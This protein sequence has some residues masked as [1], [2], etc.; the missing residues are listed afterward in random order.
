MTDAL[1]AG[2]AEDP[3]RYRV[4]A[5]AGDPVGA[6]AG[7]EGLVFRA[8]ATGDEDA[9]SFALKMLTTLPLDRYPQLVD[10]TIP[11]LTVDHPHLM[12]HVET[13]LG[14]ALRPQGEDTDDF[15]VPYTVAEWVDGVA[16]PEAA[17]AADVQARLRWV[18]QIARGVAHLQHHCTDLSPSGIVHRDIKPSN[19]RIN[20]E[21]QAVLLDFGISRPHAEDD[22]TSGAGTFNW[23]APEV[24]T[25]SDAPGP[26]SDVWGIGA[27]GYWAV[28]GE[29]PRLEGRA[30]AYERLLSAARNHQIGDAI[31]VAHHIAR[32][33]ESAPADRPSNLLRWAHEL[34]ALTARARRP[35]VQR[36]SVRVAAALIA[37]VPLVAFAGSVTMQR[38]S[39]NG[40][41]T[42]VLGSTIERGLLFQDD[43]DVYCDGISTASLGTGA[44]PG[45]TIN[46]NVRFTGQLGGGVTI[47]RG[48]D[49]VPEPPLEPPSEASTR[50]AVNN[51]AAD[52]QSQTVAREDGSFSVEWSCPP[53]SI[54]ATWTITLTPEE[55]N[56][57]TD[58]E[59]HGIEPV[60]SIGAQVATPGPDGR[61]HIP[62]GTTVEIVAS[63]VSYRNPIDPQALGLRDA[64]VTSSNPNILE[65]TPI[66][67]GEL[68][69]VRAKAAGE[70]TVA[71]RLRSLEVLYLVT[72]DP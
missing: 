13:F 42:K 69:T 14:S 56:L 2:P 34:E 1:Y 68:Y 21:D 11:L 15:D 30:T 59:I 50:P 53:T 23:R 61:I 6:M 48:P 33:L 9:R 31:G 35:Y 28:G 26:A 67:P 41:G 32:L 38:E 40:G 55:T 45:E 58:A 39:S 12:R 7:G 16:L 22:L 47:E 44:Q 19:V 29:A 4:D 65:V 25:G 60:K 71:A 51:Q 63:T 36:R 18:A 49:V 52:T 70:V 17:A 20:P 72:V 43:W 46:V 24:L 64:S 3:C 66:V 27:L 37:G 5:I 57:A 54:G 8:T 62:A 10:R